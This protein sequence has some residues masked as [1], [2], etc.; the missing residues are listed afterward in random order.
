MAVRFRFVF[1][2]ALCCMTPAGALTW[3][4]D[5]TDDA[6]NR[7]RAAET[8]IGDGRFAEAVQM[9]TQAERI[10]AAEND[11]DTRIEILRALATA[12]RALGMPG[13]GV[14]VLE[15]ALAL[16]QATDG[17]MR[18]VLTA[19][20]GSLASQSGDLQRGRALL[21]D[22]LQ[23]ARAQDDSALVA[24][25]LNDL[26]ALHRGETEN[27]Q[28]LAL[29]AEAAR[30]AQDTGNTA[31]ALEASLNAAWLHLDRAEYAIAGE[32]LE[33]AQRAAQ[34]ADTPYRRLQRATRT[35]QL[36]LELARREP[37][38]RAEAV[39]SA[40]SLLQPA[41]KLAHEMDAPRVSSA[42]GGTL[43]TAYLLA[44]RLDD[45][46]VLTRD[47]ILAAQ[48]AGA[49]QLL[50]RWHWQA[51]RIF[52]A[53]RQPEKAIASYRHAYAAY[54]GVSL[55]AAAA[56]DDILLALESPAAAL[57]ELA[58]LLLQRSATLN[59][60]AR[61]RAYLVEARDVVERLKAQ[62]LQDYF[63]DSCIA[64]ARARTQTV[65][66]SLDPQTAVLYPIVF[67]DRM[68]LL[69]SHGAEIRRV[70]VAVKASAVAAAARHLRAEL[71]KQHS[72]AYLPHAQELYQW[73]V[74][75][76]EPLLTQWRVTTLVTVPDS[77]LRAMPFAALHDGERFLIDRLAVAMV[78]GLELTD[79]RP[80]STRNVSALM[81]GLT[82]SV[83]GYPALI[84]VES[85]LE[86]VRAL[87][88]GPVIMNEAFQRERLERELTGK[89][90]AIAHIA[91]H[92]EFAGDV[93]RSFVLSYDGKIGMDELARYIGFNRV[94]DDPVD[95][96]T[97]SAC[98]TAVG[99]ERAA[100]GLAGIAVKAGARSALASLWPIHDEATSLLMTEFYR[101]LR[102]PGVSKAEAL[103]RGQTKLLGITRYRHPGY[104]SAFV[105]IGSW[106]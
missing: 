64:D 18:T 59:E 28:A 45:A 101:Q 6:G 100:L 49:N 103:R 67:A 77:T 23:A 42:I 51:G 57:L 92:G 17:R 44:G 86:N 74:R 36:L 89:R 8:L 93:R 9:L 68:E 33:R 15:Q 72:L 30:L 19:H 38:A 56:S 105:L 102:E 90:Y 66:Q 21:T 84:N 53:Q 71:E 83:Q 47:A 25:I 5:A 20:I 27:E 43:G 26:G 62:E 14:T 11:T 94:R 81:L 88:D 87:Y 13:P 95:L 75:P 10:S 63:R 61:V 39:K 98:H 50:I 69:L 40:H 37:T 16:T 58:D 7:L 12:Y 79:P 46:L 76:I 3:A 22:A 78:P 70:T 2:F 96:L 35:A 80:M 48:R 60:A 31:I 55:A 65:E 73:L 91:S 34:A 54:R 99:D 52:R 106:R 1:A 82:E 32:L 85:E 104:W 41:T 24:A 4:Q 29:Y 97:L